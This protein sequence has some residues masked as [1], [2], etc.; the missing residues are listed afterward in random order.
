MEKLENLKGVESNLTIFKYGKKPD[1]FVTH[2]VDFEV[3]DFEKKLFNKNQEEYLEKL[4]E[5]FY[6]Q[7]YIFQLGK[8]FGENSFKYIYVGLS[9]IVPGRMIFITDNNGLPMKA[10]YNKTTEFLTE[11]F[12]F[13]V[14]KDIPVA[15]GI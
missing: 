14:I 13:N 10:A 1:T 3:T 9:L 4:K 15:E 7:N 6:G 2:F 12:G 11:T 8:Y 5:D